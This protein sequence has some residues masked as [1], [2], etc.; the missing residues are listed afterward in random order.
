MRRQIIYIL[1]L[2]WSLNSLSQVMWQFNRDTVHTWH[3]QEGDEFNG[4][5]VNTSYWAYSL[6][7]HSLYMNLEQQ[8]YTNGDNHTVKNGLLVINAR[9]EPVFKRTVD[10]KR[11]NDSLFAGKRFISLNKTNYAYTSGKLATRRTFTNGFFECR[12]RI[13]KEHGYWPAFWLHGGDPNEEIDIFEAETKRP[14]DIHVD[15][16]CPNRCDMVWRFVARESFGTWLKTSV[17]FS[18]DFNV[19]A[20]EWDEE[21]IKFYLNGEFVAVAKVNFRIPKHLTVNLAV[22]SLKGPYGPGPAA[23]DSSANFEVD[24]VRVWNRVDQGASPFNIAKNNQT[25]GATALVEKE[26]LKKRVSKAYFG[27]KKEAQKEGIKVS[28]LRKERTFQF[29][30][31]G[32]T[33][34]ERPGF[35]MVSLDRDFVFKGELDKVFTQFELNTLKKGNYSLRLNWQNRQ[36]VYAFTLD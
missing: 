34:G 13:P 31:L 25:M 30:V 5:S 29:T 11:D 24:Y 22:P 23:A 9:K 3:Y 7:S 19:M 28:L 1:C 2:F 20:C 35:E 4:D 6:W 21:Q 17:D 8:Y 26:S 32:N 14:N 15:T 27:K 36:A 33:L 16:H 18:K 10:Y 12:F